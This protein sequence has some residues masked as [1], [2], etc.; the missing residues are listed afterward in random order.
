[1][2]EALLKHGAR[3][4]VTG[5]DPHRGREAEARLARKG[6]ARFVRH[7]AAEDPSLEFL[8]AAVDERFEHLDGLINNVGGN[9]VKPLGE[10]SY[11]EFLALVRVNLFTTWHGVRWGAGRIGPA[12]RS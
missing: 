6:A 1:M 4:I 9:V 8:D 5:R 3:V 12:A 7:D 2:A 11:V 10:T